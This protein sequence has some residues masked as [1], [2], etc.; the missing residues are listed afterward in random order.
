[1]YV[2]AFIMPGQFCLPEEF[3]EILKNDFTRYFTN[4]L[5]HKKLSKIL[6]HFWQ[7][8]GYNFFKKTLFELLEFAKACFLLTNLFS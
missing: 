7:G 5:K 4:E 2:Y 3:L 1:M 6:K 8:E